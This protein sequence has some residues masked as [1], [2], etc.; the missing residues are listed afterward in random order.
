M[1]NQQDVDQRGISGSAAR[2][3][4]LAG[5]PVTERRV[6]LAGVSTA[7]LEGGE[8]PPMIL[9]HGGIECGAA[10]W[11]PVIEPLAKS[12]RLIVPDG[13]GLGES[14]PF[15]R[16]DAD[17]FAAWFSEVVRLA[18]QDKPV[19][20][21]HSLF[22]SL[23]ARFAAQRGELLNRLVIYAA[24]AVGPYRMPLGLMVA[25]TLFG[26]RPTVRNAE[27]FD[28]FALHD[29]DAT[30]RRDPEW[31]AAFDAYV[32]ERAVVPHVKRT[33]RQ[34]I[35]TQTK[36]IPDD[37]LARITVQTEL[38]WGRHDRMVRLGVG[39][40]AEK[41]HSWP[42]HIIEGVAHAP[43]IEQ[44]EAFVAALTEIQAS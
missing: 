41:K 16:L 17:T 42:M 32:R 10:M 12:Q 35:R 9:M 20:V 4:M 34:L 31:Y 37:E 14:Q 23:A 11:A 40:V 21:A 26:I 30:R 6:E 43:H 38:L 33:M 3:R 15:D 1:D 2:Q 18:G 39:E 36:P 22:G 13:P 19:L 7:V 27:R 24:P 29:L 44:P 8:G 28:R 5:V 25:A